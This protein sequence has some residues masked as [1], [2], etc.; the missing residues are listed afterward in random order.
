MQKIR[1][2]IANRIYPLKVNPS[3]EE[4]LRK[5][6]KQINNMI[7]EYEKKYAVQDKQD[8][9]AMCALQIISQSKN[10]SKN[11]EDSTNEI[12]L[13]LNKI[14]TFVIKNLNS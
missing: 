10:F 13:E 8:S 6:S 1:L 7:I 11:E 2:N 5:A 3:Q 9:L 12:N 4:V 14:N